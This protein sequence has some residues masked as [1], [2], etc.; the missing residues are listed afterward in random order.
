MKFD[1]VKTGDRMTIFAGDVTQTQ[2]TPVQKWTVWD[3][4]GN[5]YVVT[6]SDMSWIETMNT[7]YDDMASKVRGAVKRH[8][9]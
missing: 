6:V 2:V 3:S 7:S 5:G 1:V 8:A 9:K 4:E